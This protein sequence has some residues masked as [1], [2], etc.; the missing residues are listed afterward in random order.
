M[1]PADSLRF[2]EVVNGDVLSIGD[3][4]LEIVDDLNLRSC[5]IRLTFSPIALLLQRMADV[6]G[7][8]AYNC[9][10]SRINDV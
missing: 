3:P 10:D 4:D 9:D 5:V 2:D 7:C 1:L 8:L 6:E